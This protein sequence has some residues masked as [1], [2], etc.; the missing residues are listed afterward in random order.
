MRSNTKDKAGLARRDLVE[1]LI[2]EEG[3]CRTHSPDG[4]F[5]ILNDVVVDRGPNPSELLFLL[6]LIFSQQELVFIK[7]RAATNKIHFSSDVLH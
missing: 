1:E 7:V 6:P 2:E 4:H 5:Q 3:E